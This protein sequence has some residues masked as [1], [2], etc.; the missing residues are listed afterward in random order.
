M[1]LRGEWFERVPLQEPATDAGG[2]EE[3]LRQRLPPPTG[4]WDIIIFDTNP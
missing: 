2:R 1:N 3:L 4:D